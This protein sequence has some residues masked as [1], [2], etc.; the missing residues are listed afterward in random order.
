MCRH[1]IVIMADRPIEKQRVQANLAVHFVESF[2]RHADVLK[3][4][5]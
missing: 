3:D 1:A 5:R 2:R 4:G